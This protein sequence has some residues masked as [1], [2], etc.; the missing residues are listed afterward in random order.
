MVETIKPQT[1]LAY[2]CLVEGQSPLAR[3]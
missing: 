1:K 2:G 3:A